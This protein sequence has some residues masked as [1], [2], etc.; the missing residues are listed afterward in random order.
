LLLPEALRASPAPTRAPPDALRAI[1]DRYE[2]EAEQEEGDDDPEPDCGV[3][4]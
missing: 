3:M 4:L 1:A 2:Q